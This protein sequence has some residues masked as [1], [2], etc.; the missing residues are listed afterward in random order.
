MREVRMKIFNRNQNTELL[1]P[2]KESLEK[3]KKFNEIAELIN[4]IFL[5]VLLVAMFIY[6]AIEY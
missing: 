3:K 1:E 5:I 6:I 4:A 2:T